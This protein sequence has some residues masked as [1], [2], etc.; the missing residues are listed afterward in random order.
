VAN[1]GGPL[2][3]LL[4]TGW[5]ASERRNARSTRASPLNSIGYSFEPKVRM[6]SCKIWSKF[7][8][9]LSS[10]RPRCAG[11]RREIMKYKLML[12]AFCAAAAHISSGDLETSH[13]GRRVWAE[14]GAKKINV[15]SNGVIL[16]GY[17]PVA[18][19]TQNKAVKGDPKYQ[20]TY[21]GAIYYFSSAA[22]LATFKKNPSKYAPQYGGFC[23]NSVKN[24]KLV[25]SDPSVFFI[26]KGKLYVCS[27]PKA[28]KEFQVHTLEDIIEANRN[29]E[30]LNH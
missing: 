20:T 4:E 21:Q 16:K 7:R 25:D 1:A 24:K 15:D 9:F 14:K 29:W 12:L 5:V 28:A 26:V 6:S 30:Q 17:D 18:Y 3:R 19:F 2:A 23:A 8:L 10:I 13:L 27:T 11:R 22:D